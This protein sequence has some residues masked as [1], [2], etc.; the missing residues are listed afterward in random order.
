VAVKVEGIRFPLSSVR[1][2]SADGAG[3]CVAQPVRARMKPTPIR[4]DRRLRS[5]DVLF[6]TRD[7]YE[8]VELLRKNI[9]RR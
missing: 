9:R 6:H 5:M 3:R 4:A 8:A 1:P 2:Q 7:F